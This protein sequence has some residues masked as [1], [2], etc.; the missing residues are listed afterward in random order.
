MSSRF[1]PPL[2]FGAP[3]NEGKTTLSRCRPPVGLWA[4]LALATGTAAFALLD[5][6]RVRHELRE[7]Q[8]E[9][10]LQVDTMR[11]EKQ[12]ALGREKE[13]QSQLRSQA[14]EQIHKQRRVDA[15]TDTV[16]DSKHSSANTIIAA[17]RR[18]HVWKLAQ[19][20]KH[21]E[22][23]QHLDSAGIPILTAYATQTHCEKPTYDTRA[24]IF[25]RVVVQHELPEVQ[26]SEGKEREDDIKEADIARMY[27]EHPEIIAHAKQMEKVA[28]LRD[29]AS[30]HEN[31]LKE[32]GISEEAIQAEI[33][34]SVQGRE[35]A[36]I[37]RWKLAAAER[38]NTPYR[39]Y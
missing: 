14:A 29:A 6:R 4:S 30:L 18:F 38:D 33:D 2:G 15:C 17:L 12:Q 13:L 11:A 27:T 23:K 1:W 25:A 7:M 9:N 24:P 37:Q 36:R 16:K 8:V 5:A 22:L 28:Q 21:K 20:A 26:E 3:K 31:S 39:Y 32:K 34:N 19:K 35:A 10:H